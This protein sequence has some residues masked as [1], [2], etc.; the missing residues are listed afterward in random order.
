MKQRLLFKPTK[1]NFMQ[2]HRFLLIIPI[3]CLHFS[4]SRAQAK[5]AKAAPA[6]YAS[7]TPKSHAADSAA[8]KSSMDS[9][10]YDINQIKSFF[11]GKNRDTINISIP[12]IAFEDASLTVFKQSVQGTKGVKGVTMGYKSGN[13]M[14]KVIYHGNSTQLWDALS[15]SS[16]QSFKMVEADDNN[17]QLEAEG[18]KH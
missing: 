6:S 10:K 12:N 3:V 16:K 2:M 8:A 11:K 9:L 13:A 1:Y 4:Q 5:Q 14:L 7:A 15:Q 17:M 18:A